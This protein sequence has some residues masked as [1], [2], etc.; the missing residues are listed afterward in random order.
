MTLLERAFLMK[1][2]HYQDNFYNKGSMQKDIYCE[3]S[4]L[5]TCLLKLEDAHFNFESY[6]DYGLWSSISKTLFSSNI[7]LH[8]DLRKKDFESEI[9]NI[10]KERRKA[11]R[12]GK[13]Y[14]MTFREKI[15]F[16]LDLKLRN[17]ELHLDMTEPN[18]L[19]HDFVFESEK[20]YNGIYFT[21]ADKDKCQKLMDEYGILVLC[22]ENIMNYK[23][24]LTDQGVAIYKNNRNDWFSILHNKILPCNAMIIVD[25]YILNDTNLM[26]ENLGQIIA[27]I[28]PQINKNINFQI[29]IFTTLR[30]D[31]KQDLPVDCRMEIIKSLIEGQNI[32]ISIIKCNDIF[33]DRM[34]LTNNQFIGSGYG[35]G[36]FMN[37]ISKKTTTISIVCPFINHSIKW[38]LEGYSNVIKDASTL[39]NNRGLATYGGNITYSFKEFIVG[40]RVNRMI[41]I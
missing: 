34:I 36:L 26:K 27:A 15:L 30:N 3:I 40:N 4:F 25:N 20:H 35:F 22:P 39:F 12:K 13:D 9:E 19:S 37:K 28:K 2:H 16:E 38:A 18:P 17:Q 41:D 7:K 5:L 29:S 1:P 32:D 23:K 10:D 24:I 8:L 11:A 14:K 21:C 33:H 6:N 31:K